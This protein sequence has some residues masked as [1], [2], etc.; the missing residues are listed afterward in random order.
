MVLRLVRVSSEISSWE[1]SSKKRGRG[2]EELDVVGAS[3]G[4]DEEPQTFRSAKRALYDE[5]AAGAVTLKDRKAL[6]ERAQSMAHEQRGVEKKVHRKASADHEE[7]VKSGNGG[8]KDWE[9]I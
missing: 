9:F 3:H 8:E 1:R 2:F 7:R 4:E 5:N 6:R